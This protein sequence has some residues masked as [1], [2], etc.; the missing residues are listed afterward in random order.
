MADRAAIGPVLSGLVQI[1]ISRVAFNVLAGVPRRRS[2]LAD[3]R[4]RRTEDGRN[5][6]Q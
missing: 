5:G 1:R 2:R 6:S 3:E 4:P